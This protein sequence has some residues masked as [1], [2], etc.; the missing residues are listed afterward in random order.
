MTWA[1][2]SEVGGV[3]AFVLGDLVLALGAVSG[4][5]VAEP[6][7]REARHAPGWRV[8]RQPANEGPEILDEVPGQCSPRDPH[9]VRGVDDLAADP[10]VPVLRKGQGQGVL[11]DHDLDA[12]PRLFP[13]GLHVDDGGVSV[14]EH[15]EVGTTGQRGGLPTQ[16]ERVLGFDVD[17][18]TADL[19]LSAFPVQWRRVAHQPL[20]VVEVGGLPRPF[21]VMG[22]EPDGPLAGVLARQET[23][24]PG[25]PDV[26]MLAGAGHAVQECPRVCR[27]AGRL[28]YGRP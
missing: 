20:G 10:D 22:L 24:Q 2:D 23:G 14:V 4:R 6:A 18:A 26:G 17:V 21:D 28:G 25:G 16:P 11:V 19:S 9:G 13:T 12:V 1:G 3:S 15:H 7:F 5:D 27:S 8:G